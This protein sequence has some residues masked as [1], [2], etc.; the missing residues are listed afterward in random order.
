MKLPPPSELDPTQISKKSNMAALLLCIFLGALG[1]HRFYVGKMGTG[2]LM[3]ITL[4]GFGIWNLFD[5]IIISC[6]D[7]RDIEGKRLIW[8]TPLVS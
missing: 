4:G 6:Q 8:D 2:L 3:L 5:L 7:F 1:A